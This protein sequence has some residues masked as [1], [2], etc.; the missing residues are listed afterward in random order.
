MGRFSS[1]LIGMVTVCVAFSAAAQQATTQRSASTPSSFGKSA[2]SAPTAQGSI[3]GAAV[4]GS[5]FDKEHRDTRRENQFS[6]SSGSVTPVKNPTATAQNAA[7]TIR[8][9]AA[10]M[11][12][13]TGNS[14]KNTNQKSANGAF[15]KE[16]SS[17]AG[18]VVEQSDTL[19]HPATGGKVYSP[20]IGSS[21]H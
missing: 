8:A 17:G 21:D 14:V 20:A 13:P 7:A 5:S 18:A 4:K 10:A 12:Q 3:P 16:R 15:T 11:Q 2:F 19:Y 6:G 1:A 9:N